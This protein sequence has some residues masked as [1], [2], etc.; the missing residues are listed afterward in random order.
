MSG[1]T[2]IFIF[3]FLV[4]VSSG[5]RARRELSSAVDTTNGSIEELIASV[6]SNNITKN[7]FYIKKATVNYED[8]LNNLSFLFSLKYDGK[9]NYLSVVRTLT[10]IELY[11]LFFNR[12]SIFLNDRLSKRLLIGKTDKV[13]SK[14]GLNYDNFVLL[15]GDFP[16]GISSAA[17]TG[18]CVGNIRDFNGLFNGSDVRFLI[19]CTEVKLKT[20]YLK[21]IAGS[22]D[23]DVEYN[24]YLRIDSAIYP[25]EIF[26]RERTKGMS[27]GII[28]ESVDI[29][30][31]EVLEFSP[32]KDYEIIVLN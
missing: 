13:L 30:L 19:S 1:K 28:F 9:G 26:L 16:I 10:G 3:L 24:G 6:A 29:P 7:S 15:L 2:V 31:E 23:V 21:K 25:G 11:R 12:D 17:S 27:V 14:Y 18:P 32:G 22:L 8:S 4:L 20:I 5:C